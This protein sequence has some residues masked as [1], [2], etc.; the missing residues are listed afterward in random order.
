MGLSEVMLNHKKLITGILV[1]RLLGFKSPFK[2]AVQWEVR[3]HVP[4][5]ED[6]HSYAVVLIDQPTGFVI[7]DTCSFSTENLRANNHQS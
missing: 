1:W 6:N 4:H 5:Q 2:S 7:Y 3:K